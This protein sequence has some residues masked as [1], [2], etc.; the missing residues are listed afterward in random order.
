MDA[1]SFVQR[2]CNQ[3]C[4]QRFDTW[5]IN[6][7]RLPA[8]GPNCGNDA[9]CVANV[10]CGTIGFSAQALAH[11]TRP[12]GGVNSFNQSVHDGGG[13]ICNQTCRTGG[14]NRNPPYFLFD[15]ICCVP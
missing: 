2:E 14:A 9:S 13:G 5:Q 8:P 11:N 15:L 1:R 4:D 12:N 3:V 10:V 7:N 6:R